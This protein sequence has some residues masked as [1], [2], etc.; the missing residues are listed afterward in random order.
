MADPTLTI[1]EAALATGLSQKAIR[2][3][4]ERGT[5]RASLQGGRVR[6]PAQELFERN[7]LVADPAEA[8]ARAAAARAAARGGRPR[9]A[10]SE[11]LERLERQAE[12][13]GLL[14]A[15]LEAER[16]RSALLAAALDARE[17]AD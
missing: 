15:E 6:I 5:L 10:G 16:E 13:I 3:R 7:L 2:R 8:P 4:I 14:T 11:L 12:R 17:R 9:T 1:R